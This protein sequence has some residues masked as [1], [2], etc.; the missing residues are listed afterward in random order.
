MKQFVSASPRGYNDRGLLGGCYTR[1]V[2]IDKIISMFT[3][4]SVNYDYDYHKIVMQEY[5]IEI[6]QGDRI[7]QLNISEKDYNK[8]L[9]KEKWLCH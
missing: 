8:L 7:A 4:R 2:N 9:R 3:M 5:I 1:Q 6:Q